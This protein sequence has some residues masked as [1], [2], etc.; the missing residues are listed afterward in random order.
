VPKA[1]LDA[2]AAE[3]T[4]VQ[5]NVSAEV[6]CDDRTV[7]LTGLY[8][9]QVLPGQWTVGIAY[10]TTWF[11]SPSGAPE[12]GEWVS[13]VVAEC[14]ACDPGVVVAQVHSNVPA[15][16]IRKLQTEPHRNA[17]RDRDVAYAL[18]VFGA[19]YLPNRNHLVRDL[20]H[21]LERPPN[22]PEDDLC[23]ERLVEYIANLYWR[24][25]SELLHLLF[26]IA[27]QRKDVVDGAGMFYADLL[28]RRPDVAVAALSSFSPEK[29]RIACIM[30]FDNELRFDGRK[31]DRIASKLR[32]IGTDSGQRCLDALQSD[33]SKEGF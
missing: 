10:P 14:N 29:Q 3:S 6:T 26:D 27:E 21:C 15:T 8:P 31:F 16:E 12:Q 18:A 11:D 32:D 25:D 1:I 4:R 17:E 33:R 22:S 7:E 28:D 19:N 23:D 13:Y 2:Y 9:A 20:R 24:G 30:A 5:S